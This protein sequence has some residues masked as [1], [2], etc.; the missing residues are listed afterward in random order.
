MSLSI[1]DDLVSRKRVIT[2]LRTHFKGLWVPAFAGM[3]MFLLSGLFGASQAYAND[4]PAITD[5]AF[6]QTC[7]AMYTARDADIEWPEEPAGDGHHCILVTDGAKPA[8]MD[9]DD[10]RWML[11]KSLT[12]ACKGKREV[13]YEIVRRL[14][15]CGGEVRTFVME[16]VPETPGACRARFIET[17]ERFNI[18]PRLIDDLVEW[19]D[20]MPW[21]EAI[22]VDLFAPPELPIIMDGLIACGGRSSK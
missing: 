5:P 1:L 14:E 21:Y 7:E 15:T 6:K 13:I 10:Y 20:E 22:L 17:G 4:L 11:R 16:P 19:R 3:T 18:A 9:A 8:Q 12:F 2:Q